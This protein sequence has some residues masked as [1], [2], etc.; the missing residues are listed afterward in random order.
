M[1]RKESAK[2][3]MYFGGGFTIARIFSYIANN[4]DTYCVN[5]LLN[6]TALGFYS[7]AYQLLMYPTSLIGDSLDQV[8]FPLLAKKQDDKQW[9]Y[10]V[11]AG[12]TTA[13]FAVSIPI[14]IFC[15]SCAGEIVN[16]MYGSQ[17]DNT[18]MPFK[19]FIIG[20]FFRIGYKISDSLVRALG[21]V[22]KRSFYQIIYATLIVIGSIIGSFKGI[23]GVAIGVTIAFTV[24]Y[25]LMTNLSLKLLNETW[26]NLIRNLIFPSV[27]GILCVIC[28][29]F[30]KMFISGINQIIEMIL[31][32]SASVVF[33]TIPFVIFKKDAVDYVINLLNTTLINRKQVK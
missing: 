2:A 30:L 19:I 32:V 26:R 12:S 15:F 31:I 8:C 9:L 20:L 4:G 13:V 29:Y 33:Y 28:V 25:I 5:K 7:K 18:I 24:N 22:Y 21:K 17:W 23:S 1:I 6:K 3:L 27:C 11:F 14:S 16:F 10:K